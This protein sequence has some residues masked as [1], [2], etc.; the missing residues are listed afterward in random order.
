M[1]AIESDGDFDAF[2]DPAVFGDAGTYAGGAPPAS[3]TLAG[4]F[5][6]AHAVAAPLGDWQGV[7]TSA[8]IF[9]CRAS[10]LPAGAAAGD[11]LTLG[12]TVWTVRDIQPDG[13][14]LARLILE[15]T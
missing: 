12:G 10:A 5:A 7:S 3:V 13:T 11:T 14:G 1:P 6:N 9:T 4:I 15:R 2:F 8:P